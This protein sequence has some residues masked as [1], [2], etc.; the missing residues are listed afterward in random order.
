M[1]N[2]YVLSVGA[3]KEQIP[4]ILKAKE[5]GLKVVAIDQDIDAQGMN[6]ADL[7]LHVDI[8][9]ESE[10]LKAIVDNN[11]SIVGIIPSP[12]G[13]YLTTVGFINDKLNLN[14]I[15]RNAAL[16][17]V[18]KFLFNQTLKTVFPERIFF[19]LIQDRKQYNKFIQNADYPVI[20][21]PRYGSG[22]RGLFIFCNVEEAVYAEEEIKFEEDYIVEKFVAGKEYGVDAVINKGKFSIVFIREKHITELPFRQAI[23]LNGPAYFEKNIEEKIKQKIEQAVKVLGLDNCLI[24]LD[25]ILTPENEVH[26]IELSGRPGGLNISSKIIPSSTGVDYLKEG[27]QLAINMPSDFTPRFSKP[28]SFRFINKSFSELEKIEMNKDVNV[29]EFSELRVKP[30]STVEKGADVMAMNFVLTTGSDLNDAINK[31]NRFI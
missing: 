21:K 10:V 16:K 24:N 29:L 20:F 17:C 11:I 9:D 28:I 1:N 31:A 15:S 27:I 14:G 6:F 22:S 5:V 7:Q 23:A 25:M 12:I 3:G 2:N 30:I 26:I 4:S 18:D 13:R 19:D 8:K